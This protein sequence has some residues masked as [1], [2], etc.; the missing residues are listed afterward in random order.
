MS[1]G[2]SAWQIATASASAAWFGAGTSSS[3]RIAFTIFPTCSLSAR[4]YPHTDC[5]TVAGALGYLLRE[6]EADGS[7]FGRWG[8]NYIYGTWSVLTALNA[9][10]TDPNTAPVR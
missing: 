9:A 2:A 5:L 1:G 8:T 3:E 6:Q 7:W 10:G 4:P